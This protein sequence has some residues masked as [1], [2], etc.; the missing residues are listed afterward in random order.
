MK[1]EFQVEDLLQTI[2]VSSFIFKPIFLPFLYLPSK[3]RLV[4]FYKANY[5]VFKLDLVLICESFVITCSIY[6][7]L[8]FILIYFNWRYILLPKRISFILFIIQCFFQKLSIDISWLLV[9]IKLHLFLGF[10]YSF[11]KIIWLF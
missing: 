5:L 6:W 3:M 4:C 2:P 1:I 7:N 8:I 9:L 11:F 10:L